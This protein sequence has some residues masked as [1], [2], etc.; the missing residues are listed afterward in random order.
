MGGRGEKEQGQDLE[1]KEGWR[2]RSKRREGRGG[3]EEVGCP[4]RSGFS[5]VTRW[6]MLR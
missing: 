1:E 6:P 2:E 4:V 3:E 5:P